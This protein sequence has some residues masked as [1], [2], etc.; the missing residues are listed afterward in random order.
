MNKD[1]HLA[2]EWTE[3]ADGFRI[4]T[5][6]TV[7][8]VESIA[9]VE[10]GV[11][12]AFCTRCGGISEGL[13]ENLNISSRERDDPAAVAENWRRL[14]Q[15]FSLPREH[16]VTVSQVHG[17]RITHYGNDPVGKE[18]PEADGIIT[19]LPGRACAVKT[20]DCLPIL[21]YDSCKKAV[22][23]VHAGWRGT[24]AGIASRA[25]TCFK[26]IIGSSPSDVM[27]VL[28]P[29]IGPCCYEIDEAVATQINQREANLP[30]LHDRGKGKWTFDLTL[31]NERQLLNAGIRREALCS[32][33]LCTSCRKDLFF[34]HRRDGE[35]TGRHLNFIVL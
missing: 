30:A 20:A 34:S 6:G 8:V 29:S 14:S 2:H 21:L 24:A 17:T 28:G 1:V 27:A 25:V 5:R 15:A 3:P 35:K 9:L 23:A 13:C 11:K 12:H 26:E 32:V 22:G 19:A 31:A 4:I 33:R 7:T 10:R 18:E 16:V